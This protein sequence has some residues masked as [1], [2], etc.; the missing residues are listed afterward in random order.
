MAVVVGVGVTIAVPV[1]VGVTIAIAV[2]V[3]VGDVVRD[4]GV[5]NFV[6]KLSTQY[7]STLSACF[8]I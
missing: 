8:D 1:G 6:R 3:A 5:T 7:L 2:A 4:V